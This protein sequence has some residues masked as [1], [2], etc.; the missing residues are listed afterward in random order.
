MSGQIKKICWK[1]NKQA[2]NIGTNV[3]NSP[4][5]NIELLNNLNGPLSFNNL[6]NISTPKSVSTSIENIEDDQLIISEL[7]NF[8]PSANFSIQTEFKGMYKND[9]NI[10]NIHYSI[11]FNFDKEEKEKIPMYT[12]SLEELKLNNKLELQN[13]ISD[14]SK[15]LEELIGQKNKITYLTQSLP[16]LLSYKKIKPLTKKISL[17]RQTDEVEL[18]YTDERHQILSGYIEIAK[19]YIS[20]DLVRLIDNSNI[21]KKC[22][23]I[24]EDYENMDENDVCPFCGIEFNSILKITTTNSDTKNIY[25]SN[26]S[27]DHNFEKAILRFEGKQI[28]KLP[29][30]I[31]KVLDDY[32]ISYNMPLSDDAKL[33]EYD[34]EN[35]CRSKINDKGIE[36]IL[37]RDIMEEALKKTKNSDFYNDMH[38]ILHLYWGFPLPDI[39]NFKEGIREDYSKTQKIF[40]TIEKDRSSSLNGDFRLLKH[41]ELRGYKCKKNQFKIIKTDKIR[42]QYEVLWKQMCEGAEL[43]YIPTNW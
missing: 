21:C 40:V 34:D 27:D 1:K 33:W 6:N 7:C 12:K 17:R 30:N 18:E 31:F 16:Y 38:L 22:T 10:L 3:P 5:S 36:I 20:I 2:N 32:Y 8:N 11:L 26:Y 29:E 23:N 19:S 28:N 42:D 37:N 14:I 15:K 35:E 13:I 41:L 9:Y 43:Q 39:S 25:R 24:I 4:T